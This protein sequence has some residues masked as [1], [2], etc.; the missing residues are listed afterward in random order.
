MGYDKPPGRA[1]FLYNKFVIDIYGKSVRNLKYPG[2]WFD[3]AILSLPL[4]NFKQLF[5]L[6][7]AENSNL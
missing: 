7:S 4:A 1:D 6:L 5:V 2:L 3:I